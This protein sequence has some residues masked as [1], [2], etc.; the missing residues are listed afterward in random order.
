MNLYRISKGSPIEFELALKH[1]ID[2]LE[3][4]G[5]LVE[6]STLRPIKAASGTPEQ[7]LLEL[8]SRIEAL[9]S[10]V[11]IFTSE[12]ITAS[13]EIIRTYRRGEPEYDKLEKLAR[14][15]NELDPDSVYT[16]Q[17]TYFDLGQDWMWT[18]IIQNPGGGGSSTQILTPRDLEWVVNGGDLNKLAADLVKPWKDRDISYES[19][20]GSEKSKASTLRVTG[21]RDIEEEIQKQM[22]DNGLIFGIGEDGSDAGIDGVPELIM[23]YPEYENGDVA[24]AVSQ[25]I[26]DTQ[27]NY[28]E[29]L[30]PGMVCHVCGK[31]LPNDEIEWHDHADDTQGYFDT[32]PDVGYSE[33]DEIGGSRSSVEYPQSNEDLVA[34]AVSHGLEWSYDDGGNLLV[35]DP[36]YDE[37]VDP[38]M[39]TQPILDFLDEANRNVNLLVEEY[40]DA[41]G[42]GYK[43][44]GSI[45]SATSSSLPNITK[46]LH[47]NDIDIVTDSEIGNDMSYRTLLKSVTDAERFNYHR[48]YW[49]DAEEYQSQHIDLLD[50]VEPY[51]GKVVEVDFE[52]DGT[53]QFKL[54]GVLIDRQY[55]SI[56][57]TRLL[58]EE[59]EDATVQEY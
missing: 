36:N 18:T 22:S 8:E 7:F 6:S 50:Q 59:Y 58:V 14:I 17:D 47:M 4:S 27:M 56:S 24:G 23:G 1:R 9:D 49:G 19:I 39:K 13:T 45:L 53:F 21:E 25:W 31:Q 16:V 44:Q 29:Y 33:M 3:R 5:D 38:D 30:V 11:G 40:E 2:L 46:L 12:S 26:F 32:E 57:H 42:V 28:P 52:D 51:I 15:L 55:N 20:R 43:S 54:L 10:D 37:D 35:W 34:L 41:F 48:D